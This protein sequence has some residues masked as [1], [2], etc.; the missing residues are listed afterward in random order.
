MRVPG[1]TTVGSGRI[2][3]ESVADP[4]GEAVTVDE[5]TPESVMSRG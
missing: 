3:S 2:G 1:S 4:L 5:W